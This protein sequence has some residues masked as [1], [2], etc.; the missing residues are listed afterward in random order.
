MFIAEVIMIASK[1]SDYEE[2]LEKIRSWPPEVRLTLAEELLRSLRPV[3]GHNGCR[4]VP[5]EQ[6]LGIGAGKGP[7]PDDET[8]KRWMEERRMEKY[9]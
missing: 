4:G 7:P 3:V 5:A 8:V 2:V 1:D 9:G 6:A